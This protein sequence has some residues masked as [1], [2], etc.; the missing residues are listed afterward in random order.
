VVAAGSR[1][2]AFDLNVVYVST[3][4]HGGPVSHLRDLVPAVAGEGVAVHVVCATTS[5]AAD[6]ERRG[7][8]TTVVPIGSKF[9]LAGAA[10]LWE[11]VRGA[12]IVHTHDRRA[13][14]FGRLA[15]RGR[16]ARV[17]HTLHGI[18]ERIALELGGPSPA[19]PRRARN[20]PADI[21]A[22]GTLRMEALLA[23]LGIVV[24]PS[25]ALADFVVQHGFPEGR[26]R[27]VPSGVTL[28]RTDP[29]PGHRPPTIGTAATL[30]VHKGV[31]VLLEACALIEEPLKLEIF[32]DGPVRTQLEELALR[33]GVDA[34]F[35][36]FV[37]DFRERVGGLDVFV[38]PTRGDNLPVAI[39][40]AMANAVPVVATR[41]GGI[42]ELV[43][44][45]E[46]GLLVAR[47]DPRA[48]AAALERLLAGEDLR[49]RLGRGGARRVERHFE[50]GEVARRMIAVYEELA[51][52]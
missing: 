17:V 26:I 36:G 18:P 45:E 50:S 14:L 8:P 27:V 24:I 38:L 6:F 33:L 13:G 46:S 5:V 3:L 44:D 25:R 47:D 48:L 42:P 49:I 15:A 52:T 19:G 1:A 43:L 51:G 41:V 9:D 28:Q 20:L 12:D 34:T 21:R 22:Y 11:P 39:L 2:D 10:G 4:P 29:V 23:H 7:V 32:G 35:H 31:D 37:D 30:D 40:E 16:R